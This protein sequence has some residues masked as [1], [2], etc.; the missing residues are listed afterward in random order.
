MQGSSRVLVRGASRSWAR[1][2]LDHTVTQIDFKTRWSP[3]GDGEGGKKAEEWGL[4]QI[5]EAGSPRERFC[6][7]LTHNP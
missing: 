6:S 3:L 1:G 2:L 5:P 7:V 4:V